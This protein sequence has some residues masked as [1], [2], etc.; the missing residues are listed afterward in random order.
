MNDDLNDPMSEGEA[1]E[2]LERKAGE[3]DAMA[4]AIL[5]SFSNP[6]LRPLRIKVAISDAL[7]PPDV[8]IGGIWRVKRDE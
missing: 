4:R 8:Q 1:L 2:Y 7:Q 5:D 3:G 6:A